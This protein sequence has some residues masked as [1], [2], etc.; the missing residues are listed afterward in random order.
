MYEI[1]SVDFH[2]DTVTYDETVYPNKFASAQDAYNFMYA[3][4]DSA[5]DYMNQFTDDL[6]SFGI[7]QTDEIDCVRVNYY[8]MSSP[9]DTTGE[10]IQ[11]KILYAKETENHD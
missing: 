8:V 4:A 9:E 10:T 1:H 2:P 7:A 3:V 11:V 6:T 5:C